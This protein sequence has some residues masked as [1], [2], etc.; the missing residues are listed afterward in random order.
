MSYFIECMLF[1]M[2]VDIY[3]KFSSSKENRVKLPFPG[4]GKLGTFGPN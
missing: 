2:K 4:S 3:L 1:R